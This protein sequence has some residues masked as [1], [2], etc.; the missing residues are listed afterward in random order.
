MRDATESAPW[1]AGGRR[2]FNTNRGRE[3]RLLFVMDGELDG[4]VTSRQRRRI[5]LRHP[6]RDE[7]QCRHGQSDSATNENSFNEDQPQYD[8]RHDP[9]GADSSGRGG[10]LR[11]RRHPRYDR[12]N[13][14]VAAVYAPYDGSARA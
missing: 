13:R 2:T 9:D 6:E 1:H 12:H 14:Q 10:Q 7:I 3:F 5:R 11:R 8:T 4:R